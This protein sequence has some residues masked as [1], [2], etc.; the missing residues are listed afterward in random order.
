[1][2]EAGKVMRIQREGG[3]ASLAVRGRDTAAKMKVGDSVSVSGVCLT[4]TKLENEDIYLQ[5]V[6]ETLKRTTLGELKAGDTVNL[7]LSLRYN[8]FVGGHLVQGHVDCTG[9]VV[10]KVQKKNSVLMGFKVPRNVVKYIVEK[11]S[12]AV[13]GISLTV[14]GVKHDVFTV[15]LIPHT[16]KS[17][18]LGFKKTGSK[19]NIETDMMAKYMENFIRNYFSGKE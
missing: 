2:Q 7:E 1:M 3:F 15:A 18:T 12:V 8:D 13:D 14:V 10:A 11:G 17:T 16:L 19:V 5:V 4:A 9:N 6:F